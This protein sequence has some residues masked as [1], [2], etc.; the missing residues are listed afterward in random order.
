MTAPKTKS[1]KKARS[2]IAQAIE[3]AGGQE[4]LAQ[5]LGVTKQAVQK[6]AQRGYVPPRRVVE[7]EAEY[8]IKRRDLIDPRLMDLVSTKWSV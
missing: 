5:R 6:W 7:I 8:G 4:P 2:G 3:L 1:L